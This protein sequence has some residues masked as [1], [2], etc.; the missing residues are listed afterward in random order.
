M[1]D[2]SRLP[3][4]EARRL[5]VLGALSA[6][7]RQAAAE[8]DPQPLA[9]ASPEHERFYRSEAPEIVASGWMGAGKSRVLCQKAVDLALRYP[10]SELGIFRKV[11]SSLAATTERT[12]WQDVVDPRLVRDRHRGE[13]W[14]ELGRPGGPASRIWLLG[15]D[16]DPVTGVP[17]KV[18]SLNLDWAGVDEAVELSEADWI[19]LGGRLR[20][21]TMP[22]RQ[23]AAATN[24]AAPSHWLKRRF[25][26]PTESREWIT[27]AQNR[28]LPPDY[29]ER[30]VG[31]GD[32]VHAQ[33]LAQ[34]LWVA[35]EGMI[36]FL[37]D[38]QVRDPSQT[39]WQR[40]VGGIDWGY[41]HPFACEIVAESGTGRR[42]TLDELSAR[43][44]V[45]DD[46]LPRLAELAARYRIDTF[47]ADPSEPEYIERARRAGL[48]IEPA[49]NDVLPGID[50][51][52]AS[53]AAGETVSPRCTALLSELPAYTWRR[54]RGGEQTEQ[55][56]ALGNDA[57]DAWRYAHM[58]L[59]VPGR[60]SGFGA[61][62][63]AETARLRAL[64]QTG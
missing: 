50:A 36:W 60:M 8:A 6:R 48:S 44:A 35:A 52:A 29:R 64:R 61:Y 18:G 54:D 3:A 24:P 39:T 56:V 41:V 42:A 33:R 22:F 20:R 38:D 62:Y 49:T 34:G 51:V 14:V 30:L 45:L 9:F 40:V 17:S 63:R 12:F 13:H 59:E 31:L 27:I 7:A 37:P 15:L 21:T 10:G 19:M 1:S 55:P 53:I 4:A 11:G 32:G 23:L 43:G 26:P 2:L 57:C 25:T 46:I 5:L 28:F 58:G 16:A 47:Y